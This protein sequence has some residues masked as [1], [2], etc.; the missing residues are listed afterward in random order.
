MIS[1][2]PAAGSSVLKR[3]RTGVRAGMTINAGMLKCNPEKNWVLWYRDVQQKYGITPYVNID[4]PDPFVTQVRY[5]AGKTELLLFINSST[6]KEHRINLTVHKDIA[7][8][9]QAWVW[10]AVTGERWHITSGSSQVALDL[11][12]ADSRLL[13]FDYEKKG[14]PW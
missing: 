7:L 9:R 11:G 14:L 5:Q 2:L 3:S 6:E 4:N 10:D 13:V 1:S 8:G 12:P